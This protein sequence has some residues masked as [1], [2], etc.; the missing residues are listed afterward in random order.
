MSYNLFLD[1]ARTPEMASFYVLPVEERPKYMKLHWITVRD[2]DQFREY[3]LRHGLPRTVSFDHDLAQE[4]ILLGHSRFANWEAYYKETDREMTGYD[5]AK[6]LCDYCYEYKV[7]LP[8]CY[9]HSQNP[10]GAKNILS[11]L[12]N[13]KK[14][15]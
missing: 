10:V 9:V 6:W 4:H 5:A 13:F 11:Y 1:D 14:H 15:R 8:E 12:K 7:P 3:I 2:F